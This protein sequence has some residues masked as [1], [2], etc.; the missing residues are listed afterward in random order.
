MAKDSE[1]QDMIEYAR[2]LQGSME[3]QFEELRK[4]GEKS[5]MEKLTLLEDRYNNQIRRY[6]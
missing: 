2:R 6:I 4:E 1:L 5:E 3:N